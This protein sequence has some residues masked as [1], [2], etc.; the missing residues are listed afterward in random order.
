V[1]AAK[2]ELDQAGFRK[3][4]TTWRDRLNQKRLI[5]TDF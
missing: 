2:I 1:R 5:L 4:L 3:C